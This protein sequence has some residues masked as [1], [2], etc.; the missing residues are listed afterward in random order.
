MQGH[1]NRMWSD[2]L[3]NYLLLIAD[4]VVRPTVNNRPLIRLYSD[5]A[6]EKFMY[7]L[8]TCDWSDISS[9][10]DVNRAYNLFFQ[11]EFRCTLMTASHLSDCLRL[12]ETPLSFEA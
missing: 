11:T 8:E 12:S 10:D 4:K 7:K 1:Q 2:H 3:P 6:R 5:K 9:H